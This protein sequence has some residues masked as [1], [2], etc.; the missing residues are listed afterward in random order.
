MY[1]VFAR[2]AEGKPSVA[3]VANGGGIT[4][5]EVDENIRAGRPIILVSGSG[6]AADVLVSLVA[7]HTADSA[8]AELRQKAEALN[9]RR[10]PD[11]F[12]TFNLT[13]GPREFARTLRSLIE[14]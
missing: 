8:E 9:L 14:R 10:R 6:R 7:N 13:D 11:L 3:V 1:K 12:H 4:L 2:L 5:A